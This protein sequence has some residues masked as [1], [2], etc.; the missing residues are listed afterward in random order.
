MRR[1]AKHRAQ[2]PSPNHGARPLELGQHNVKEA[3]AH[4]DVDGP[5]PLQRCPVCVRVLCSRR[6]HTEQ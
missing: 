5:R 6:E 4:W 3:E 2:P 1:R